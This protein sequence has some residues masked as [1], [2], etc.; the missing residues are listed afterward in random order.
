MS[1]LKKNWISFMRPEGFYKKCAT[2][3]CNLRYIDII[4][5]LKDLNVYIT[6]DDDTERLSEVL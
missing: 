6:N 5:K 4:K 1:S 3:Y 2:S